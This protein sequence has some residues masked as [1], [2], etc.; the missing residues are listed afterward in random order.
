MIKKIEKKLP[1]FLLLIHFLIVILS[2]RESPFSKLL[3]GHDSSMFIYFG[4]GMTEGLTPYTD[5]FDHKGIV[6]FWFQQIGVLLGFG[7]A[8]VGVWFVE[9]FCYG[10]AVYFVY[11]TGVY[12]TKQPLAS[13]FAPFLLTGITIATFDGGNYSEMFALPFIA[14]ALY[15]F[16][17][18][19]LSRVN[20]RWMLLCIGITGALTFFIRVNMVAL[21]FVFCMYL[22]FFGVFKKEYTLLRQQVIYIFLGSLSVCFV[23]LIYALYQGNL[24]EMIYQTFTLNMQYSTST[25]ATKLLTGKAFFELA[26]QFGVVSLF[27]LFLLSLLADKKSITPAHKPIDVAFVIYAAINFLTVILSG[28]YY[29]HYFITMLPILAV[30]ATIAVAQ[31]ASRIQK[32]HYLLYLVLLLLPLS[33][34][35]TA[36]Q[37]WSKPIL[38]SAVDEHTHSLIRQQADFIETHSEKQDPIYVHNINAN[39]YLLSNRYANSRFFVLPSLNYEAFPA[40][41]QEFSAQLKNNPPLFIAIRKEIF[42]QATPTDARM[43]KTLIDYLHTHYSIVPTFETTDILLFQ[44]R[45]AN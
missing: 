43:D 45:T 15:F 12:L 22:L 2:L 19:I 5:M 42:E 32:H 35:Y 39:L 26:S 33:G 40:L 37:A 44:K 36:Y 23:V 30:T 24:A 41:Q 17:K 8:S 25:A 9:S 38:F 34:F 3:D 14:I 28:R 1:F 4:K 29:T 21:W 6:L 20:Q 27:V 18:T 7:Q 10:V 13:A 16:V 31:L 11:K